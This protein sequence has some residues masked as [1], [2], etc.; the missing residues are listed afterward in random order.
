MLWICL[1]LPL[2]PLE[3]FTRS[4]PD[5]N[6]RAVALVQNQQLTCC[7]RVARARGILPGMSATTAGALADGLLCLEKD[8]NK[9]RLALRQLAQWAYRFTPTCCIKPPTDLLLEVGASLKLFQQLEHISGLIDAD[10][11]AQGFSYTIGLAHTPKAAWLVAR[12]QPGTDPAWFDRHRQQLDREQLNALL[13]KVP[14]QQLDLPEPV[15]RRLHKPGFRVLADILSLPRQALGKRF[16]R[17]FVLYLDQL[18]G[19]APDPQ[20]TIEPEPGFYRQLDFMEPLHRAEALLFPMQRLLD[21]LAAFLRSRQ[22]ECPGFEWRLAQQDNDPMLLPIR[23]S[24]PHHDKQR[25]LALTRTRLEQLKLVAPVSGLGLRSDRFSPTAPAT[26]VLFEEWR[27]QQQ[28]SME[29]LLDTLN[30]RLENTQIYGLETCDEHVPE[31]AWRRTTALPAANKQQQPDNASHRGD[32]PGWL[33]TQ[34]SPIRQRG[35]SL[36]WRGKLQLIIGPERIQSHWWDKPVQRDYFI[37]QHQDGGFYWVYLD[38]GQQR[39]YVHGIF[40]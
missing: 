5:A 13:A 29:L 15:L 11:Q 17:D 14:L 40:A 38:L 4:S 3:V 37:A 25:F 10:L 22:L 9:E 8:R 20:H 35:D 7:N 33:L 32:R 18:Q 1:H 12:H 23:L 31:L 36:H 19:Y 27:N 28:Q 39:W 2:L 6:T 24:R 30:T 34:P 16:G 21:E 26:T